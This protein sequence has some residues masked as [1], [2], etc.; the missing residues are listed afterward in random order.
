MLPQVQM[1]RSARRCSRVLRRRR[2]P[3]SPWGVVLVAVSEEPPGPPA[4]AVPAPA[5]AALCEPPNTSAN[6]SRVT[7]MSST[8]SVFVRKR[9]AKKARMPL[10]VSANQATNLSLRAAKKRKGNE[11]SSSSAVVVAR[12]ASLRL[13]ERAAAIENGFNFMTGGK[14]ASGSQV[15]TSINQRF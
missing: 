4:S 1:S 13:C 8:H 10:V 6:W 2:L 15:Q 9:S 5:A 7:Q 3:R 14:T 12:S 11:P